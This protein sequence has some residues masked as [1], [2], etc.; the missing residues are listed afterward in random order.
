MTV[1]F[2]SNFIL[3]EANFDG[4][5]LHSSGITLEVHACVYRNSA[6]VLGG[7]ISIVSLMAYSVFETNFTTNYANHGE[8]ITFQKSHM[9]ILRVCNNILLTVYLKTTQQL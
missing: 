9:I 2:F 6:Y 4:G 3:N 8:A 5:A 7:A 1:I